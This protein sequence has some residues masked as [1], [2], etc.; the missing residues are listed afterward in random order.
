VRGSVEGDRIIAAGQVFRMAMYHP[1]HPDKD[2]KIANRV[3][4]FDEP[5]AQFGSS[6]S[7]RARAAFSGQGAL[8]KM[9]KLPFREMPAGVALNIAVMDVARHCQ[10]D[11]PDGGRRRTARDCAHDRPRV[12]HG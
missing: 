1:N 9:V 5:R 12:D 4:V 8:E 7:D 11:R 6:K 2:Y 10:G 3:E